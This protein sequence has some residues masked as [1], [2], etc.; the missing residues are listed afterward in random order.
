[1]AI[2][3]VFPGS[4][5]GEKAFIFNLSSVARTERV[6]NAEIHLFRKRIRS[7]NSTISL[8]LHRVSLNKVYDAGSVDL[9]TE[10][11]GWHATNMTP[12][13]KSC[14]SRRR[15]PGDVL[16]VTIRKV[17]KNSRKSRTMSL[18]RFMDHMTLPFLVLYSNDTQNIT[19]D[20]VDPHFRAT[21]LEEEIFDPEFGYIPNFS[22]SLSHHARTIFDYD[23]SADYDSEDGEVDVSNEK[24]DDAP[25]KGFG[26]DDDDAKALSESVADI[27]DRKRRSI[28]DN[29][30][31]EEPVDNV[32][33]GPFNVPLTNPIEMEEHVTQSQNESQKQE[34]KKEE[35][36]KSE[37]KPGK[38]IFG[39][40][41]NRKN[42]GTEEKEYDL[43]PYPK[44]FKK[45]RK[46]RRRN[47]RKN[48]KH[49][50]RRPH[51]DRQLPLPPEWEAELKK[52][53]TSSN[54]NRDKL[55]RRRKLVVDFADIGWSDW[56]INPKSFEAHYC[57]GQCPFPLT[58]VRNFISIFLDLFDVEIVVIWFISV[59]NANVRY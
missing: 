44:D 2:T 47:R 53:G 7:R 55:C 54:A 33:Q 30:I 15:S 46:N 58:K 57:S 49:R 41:D 26:F 16:A 21:D 51:Q 17:K 48:R 4:V 8:R 38:T 37:H 27:T 50:R 25:F 31:P 32:K 34:G 59:Y 35:F 6:F 9:I 24:D 28:F 12:A 19:L 13:V 52:G 56:I 1:M 29:E 11:R 42:V 43:I 20:H 10:A 23:D 5:G 39:K 45:E 40:V 14:I 36:V 3:F 22:N 18:H